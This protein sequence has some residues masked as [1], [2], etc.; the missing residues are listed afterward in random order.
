[1]VADDKDFSKLNKNN[2]IRQPSLTPGMEPK[3]YQL[4]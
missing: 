3:H 2:K 1:M 4:K